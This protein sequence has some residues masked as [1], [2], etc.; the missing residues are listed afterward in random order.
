MLQF[1]G[2]DAAGV[3]VWAA[4]DGSEVE[5]KGGKTEGAGRFACVSSTLH[6]KSGL[7]WCI[8]LR[9]MTS[10]LR[11]DLLWSVDEST[12]VVRTD[13]SVNEPYVQLMAEVATSLNGETPCHQENV[14]T[15][16]KRRMQGGTMVLLSTGASVPVD[17]LNRLLIYTCRGSTHGSADRCRVW[18]EVRD[19][20]T[21]HVE[22]GCLLPVWILPDTFNLILFGPLKK[23][24][25]FVWSVNVHNVFQMLSVCVQRLGVWYDGEKS[26]ILS[27]LLIESIIEAREAS[28]QAP[29]QQRV[30]PATRRV[31]SLQPIELAVESILQTIH[32]RQD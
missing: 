14:R 18:E 2:P 9:V 23:K 20:D 29:K 12:G 3:I 5:L 24:P 16:F 6:G 13:G 17:L 7:V 21:V 11:V 10:Q 1:V 30:A 25:L 26:Y 15:S 22:F 32:E 19:Q 27:S 31:T 28:K 8:C 4:F